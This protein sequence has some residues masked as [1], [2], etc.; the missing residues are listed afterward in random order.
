MM[1]ISP[2]F[3]IVNSIEIKSISD[4]LD[5]NKEKYYGKPGIL[6]EP[7]EIPGINFPKNESTSA[8]GTTNFFE[9][10]FPSASSGLFRGQL[11]D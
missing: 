7:P 6:Y 4:F 1:R 9:Y 2:Y 5:L 8:T 10:L 3:D 11:M